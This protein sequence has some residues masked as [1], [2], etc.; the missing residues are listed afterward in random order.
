MLL[1]KLDEVAKL[2]E[3]RVAYVAPQELVL[4]QN[5]VEYVLGVPDKPTLEEEQ[6]RRGCYC[7]KRA[8]SKFQKIAV[9]GHISPEFEEHLGCL[10]PLDHTLDVA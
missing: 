6:Y 4:K 2:Q 9:A 3:A 5:A 7:Y 1:G 10:F 8:S